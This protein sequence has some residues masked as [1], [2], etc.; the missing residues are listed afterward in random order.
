[1]QRE[2]NQE[3]LLEEMVEQRYI[4][5]RQALKTMGALV[6]SAV[7]GASCS[8]ISKKQKSES[9]WELSF[10]CDYFK[11]R[12]SALRLVYIPD[13]HLVE[14]QKRI[15]SFVRDNKSIV[16]ALCLE[17]LC[18][19]IN[20]GYQ[21]QMKK[22]EEHAQHLIGERIKFMNELR[23]RKDKNSALLRALIERDIS[24]FL[25]HSENECCP[26][27]PQYLVHSPGQYLARELYNEI[28][29]F[30]MEKRTLYEESLKELAAIQQCGLLYV[31]E[32]LKKEDEEIIQTIRDMERKL[33]LH[34]FY[35]AL[36]KDEEIKKTMRDMERKLPLQQY[37]E[38]RSMLFTKLNISSAEELNEVL[39]DKIKIKKFMGL[40]RKREESVIEN[41]DRKFKEGTLFVV[42]G[43]IHREGLLKEIEER[44]LSVA[45]PKRS[46]LS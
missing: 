6:L 37:R 15:V 10:D 24:L 23:Q 19:D 41:I 38:G 40:Q 7:G 20:E 5:R 39:S 34:Y 3:E 45:I 26:E 46:N 18:G 32:A 21:N 8:T 25:A 16:D 27:V 30:G 29:L 17:G 22:A 11:D 14:Y 4:S 2:Q 44:D 33:P 42:M 9:P 13:I 31:Y 28:P 35:E 36:K 43:A 1:M 12:K